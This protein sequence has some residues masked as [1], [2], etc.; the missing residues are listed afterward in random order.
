M[1]KVVTIIMIILV[2]TSTLLSL[3]RRAWLMIMSQEGALY[4]VDLFLY[5]VF[6]I[7]V[8]AFSALHSGN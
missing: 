4:N 1:R 5:I 6:N 8:P 7:T 2:T 3:M